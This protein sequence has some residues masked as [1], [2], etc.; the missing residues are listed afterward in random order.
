MALSRRLEGVSARRLRLLVR[1]AFIAAS[2]VLFVHLAG[3]STSNPLSRTSPVR[4]TSSTDLSPASS[5]DVALIF[6]E[7]RVDYATQMLRSAATYGGPRDAVHFHL[8]APRAVVHLAQPAL[9]ELNI[10]ATWYDYAACDRLVAPVRP[11]A[12]EAIHTSALCKVFLADLLVDVARVLYLDTDA[13][14]VGTLDVCAQ[15]LANDALFGMALDLGDACQV[16]PER[17]WP[18]SLQFTPW[19]GLVCG[20]VPKHHWPPSFEA[21]DAV[22][23]QPGE[24]EPAQVN[25]GVILMELSRMR[26]ANFTA[27][28]LASTAHAFL[29][30]DRRRATWAEQEFLN[31]YIRDYP[32]DFS[33]IPCGCNYQYVGI[34]REA[35]CAGQPVHVVHHW[36]S[37][38]AVETDNPYNRVFHHLRRNDSSALPPLPA[39]SSSSD[40]SPSGPVRV[41]LNLDCV[42]Q[43]YDCAE[44]SPAAVPPRWGDPVYVLTRTAARPRFF[45]A[46][47]ESV[48]AQ[49][50]PYVH[51]LVATDDAASMRYLDGVPG[52]DAA[53]LVP[54]RP[55]AAAQFDPDEVCRACQ[56]L[57]EP[58]R[59]CGQAP[60]LGNPLRQPYLECYC[61]S[62]YP[63]NELVNHLVRRALEL[64]QA[65]SGP[66]PGWL[67]ILDDDNVFASSSAVSD[68]MLD[69]DHDDELVLFRSKLG[70]LTPSDEG[71]GRVPV[72][73]GDI[74]ASNFMVHTSHGEKALWDAR[75]CGDWR[76]ID[77]LSELLTPKW[78]SAMPISA[79]P[80]R[81]R[82]GGLGGK[83]DLPDPAASGSK[84]KE[85]D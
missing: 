82:L 47:R 36:S 49:S 18:L 62:H 15:P 51:H 12:N 45:A 83:H 64:A 14:I 67:V 75:R 22:C 5:H 19:D 32:S 43:P 65:P 69:V 27:K 78:S 74:D 7:N 11:F 85:G 26:R 71:M 17:C 29:L 35:K 59:S 8:V 1:V 28:L 60:D 34:R 25:G 3:S 48:L 16:R 52:L 40:F 53:D 24:P 70:R 76:T 54:R 6:D 23:A 13:T 33:L 56:P 68:V 21:V 9:D 80:L 72:E 50:Y 81:A 38:A 30:A 77:R 44:A 73:R 31:A 84:E 42:G 41:E 55:S 10:R 37:N 2:L 20:N 63:M 61:A 46:A 4:R 66:G 57:N 79:H 58:G 39:L